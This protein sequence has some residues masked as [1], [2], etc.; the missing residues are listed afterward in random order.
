M[1]PSDIPSVADLYP[2][3]DNDGLLLK[4]YAAT[5]N[6]DRIGD[7][8]NPYSLDRTVKAYLATNPVLLFNHN[9]GFPAIGRVLNAEIHRDKGLWVECLMPKPAPGGLASE[10]WDAAKNGILR[11]FSVGGK[12]F[13]QDKGSHNAIM[14][15]DLI[16]ISLCNVG[17]NPDTFA[18]AIA[19]TEVKCIGAGYMDPAAYDAAVGDA[20]ERLALAEA[21][22]SLA[23]IITRTR[24]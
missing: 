9:Y 8:F 7:E 2:A 13:K 20:R 21:Q 10:I 22:M 17:V 11:A 19:P 23:E 5:W 6:R 16:E 24:A 18:T 14:D 12:W 4:G 15:A 3:A 1:N